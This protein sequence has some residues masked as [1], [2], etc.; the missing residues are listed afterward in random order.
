[1]E[2]RPYQRAAIDAVFGWVATNDGSCL[3]VLPTGSGKSLVMGALIAEALGNDSGARALII[4]HRKELIQQN[5]RAVA[6]ALPLGSIG[7]Y[8]AGLNRKDTTSQVIVGGIQSIARDPYCLDA[9]DLVCI[10][11]AHLVPNDD[12]TMYRATIDALRQL[13]PKV[14]FVG[15][16][17]TPYR[18]GSGLLH[19]GE[20]ALFND[21]AYEASIAQLI[22][23]GY[24]CPLISRATLAKLDT[25]GVQTRGGEFIPGQLERAVDIDSVT[26]K[27]V[28]E[29]LALCGNRKKLLVFCAGVKHAEHV[30][31]AFSA[32]GA[33]AAAVHGE[34][35][36]L[37]RAGAL[38]AFARGEYRVLTSVDVLTTG[39]DEPA[40][41]A[42]ILLRPTKSTGL[43]VQMVG[44]GFRLHLAKTDTL[45]LDFAGNVLRHGPVDAIE[46][47]DAVKVGGPAPAK[48]CPDCHVMLAAGIRV[49]PHCAHAFPE[50]ERPPILPEASLARILSSEPVPTRWVDVTSVEYWRHENPAKPL[51][52]LRVE[53]YCGYRRVASEWICFEHSGYAREKAVMW[54]QRRDRT[55]A[56]VPGLVNDAL[57]R[58]DDLLEPTSIELQQDGKYTRVVSYNLPE[59]PEHVAPDAA[60]VDDLPRAC[61]TCGHWSERDKLC[62]QWNETPPESVQPVGCSSW[63]SEIL[64]PF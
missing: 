44:R 57:D 30:A 7:V 15:L 45:V 23:A 19:R 11:E 53:Y 24:L 42:I 25:A 6:T 28:S 37:E 21:V 38:E 35:T 34:L 51:P 20:G 40:I 13:N 56:P 32:Q 55:R 41:D 63:T 48:E 54:W 31:A 64:I 18:L 1:M 22:E 27:V 2:L 10:D 39:Y 47:R 59:L 4:A 50:P 43:Y 26:A 52:T 33:P 17:A 61:W 29:T 9:F 60:F 46:I 62:L 14:R 12:D 58:T 49:C 5:V 36:P 8:S 16:T 3:L